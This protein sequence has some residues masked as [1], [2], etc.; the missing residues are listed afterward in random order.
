MP[1]APRARSLGGLEREIVACEACR[2]L[3]EHCIEVARVKRRAYRGEHYWGRPVPG[4]GDREARI[5]L[6]GLAPGAHGANRTG[7]MFTGDR[8]G[9]WLYRALFDAKLA[10]QAESTHRNDG[11][12]LRDVFITA[13]GRCAPPGNRPTVDELACCAPFL[14]R[15]LELLARV[16]VV[17]ALGGIAWEAA[18]R[19][20]ARLATDGR[21]PRREKFGHGAETVLPIGRSGRPVAVLGSYHPSQQNTLTGRLTRPMLDQVLRRGIELA[22]A[23]SP[24]R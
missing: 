15:E 16:R 3:R 11:L 1:V 14:D 12:T 4:F 13:A 10:S 24:G 5:L 18:R 22:E 2:R 23:G 19:R 21:P 20:A 8:S 6:L 17:L 7:R 9:E